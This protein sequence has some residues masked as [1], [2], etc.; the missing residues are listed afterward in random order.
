[1]RRGGRRGSAPWVVLHS[2]LSQQ[3]ATAVREVAVREQ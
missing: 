2:D 3:V 1:M